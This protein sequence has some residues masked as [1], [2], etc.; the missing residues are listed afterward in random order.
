VPR[1]FFFSF[2]SITSSTATLPKTSSI[3]GSARSLAHLTSQNEW[4]QR[5]FT[6]IRT[7]FLFASH[8]FSCAAS[9]PCLGRWARV[10]Q[11]FA[12]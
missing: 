5:T 3:P 8:L 7:V 12:R 2:F 11:S 1:F 10:G 6:V 9:A 4:K